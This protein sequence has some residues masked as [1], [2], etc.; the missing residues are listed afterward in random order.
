MDSLMVIYKLKLHL[1]PIQIPPNSF[2]NIDKEA[3]ISSIIGCRKFLP[4]LYDTE[5]NNLNKWSGKNPLKHRLGNNGTYAILLI[6]TEITIRMQFHGTMVPE[7]HII[8]WT[9]STTIWT[10]RLKE[11]GLSPNAENL[12]HSPVLGSLSHR[13]CYFSLVGHIC[14]Q[15]DLLCFILLLFPVSFAWPCLSYLAIEY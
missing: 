4:D 9:K 14:L 11:H 7:L 10:S 1:K 3:N 6:L 5:V 15:F 12:M 2:K 13:L 8:H